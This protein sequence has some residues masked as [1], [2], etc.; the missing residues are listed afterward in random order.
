MLKYGEINPLNV[1]NLRQ[2][3][4][5]PPHFECVQ[6]DL[7]TTEKVIT[8]WIYENLSGRFY[9]GFIDVSQP[10]NHVTFRQTIVAFE[11]ASEASYFSMFLPQINNS[12]FF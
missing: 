8:N 1:F 5:C 7:N 11:N 9:V 4:H 2:L 3:S 12:T 6:F 10:P